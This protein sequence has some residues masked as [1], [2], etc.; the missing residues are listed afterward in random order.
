MKRIL[1]FS[2]VFVAGLIL[3]LYFAGVFDSSTPEIEPA[4]DE[5]DLPVVAIAIDAGHGGRD[6]GAVADGILEKD[7]NLAI[8]KRVAELARNHPRLNPVLTRSSDI[9]I[10]KLERIRI[11]EE[12][13]AKLYLSIHA[14]AFSSTEVHGTE[15]WV[16]NT[17]ETG[18]PSWLLAEC[19]QNAL[20]EATETRDRGV[21]SQDL[22]LH[23][24]AL[25]A[26]SVEVGFLTC[27]EERAKLVDADY[28]NTVA[29]ALM[30]GVLEFLSS[31][32][33]I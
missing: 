26:A 33:M 28:Q 24:T 10:D 7:V 15:T 12:A 32:D 16:D 31:S 13:G 18:G 8:A 17:R 23:N 30:D 21:R 3:I 9:T 1:S 19:V 11:A 27:P 22:Y 5:P 14:N 29:A 25:P 20:V 4:V 2:F 6:P